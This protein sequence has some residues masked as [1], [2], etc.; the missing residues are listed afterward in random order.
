MVMDTEEQTYNKKRTCN[1]E[2]RTYNE[3]GPIIK[4]EDL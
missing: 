4:K 1:K 3:R 2:K